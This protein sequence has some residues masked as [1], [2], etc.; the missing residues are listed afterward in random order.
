MHV[1][2]ITF[3]ACSTFEQK[4]II[5]N[6]VKIKNDGTV[7]VDVDRGS[8]IA[9]TLF[10]LDIPDQLPADI[11][12]DY[13]DPVEVIPSYLEIAML[14]V[15]TRGDVQPFVAIGKRLRVCVA[16]GLLLLMLPCRQL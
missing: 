7:E 13:E 8:E 3:L 9:P 12:D 4:K 10:D 5:E 15:G 1:F 6:L 14:I 16:V 11:E 2:N